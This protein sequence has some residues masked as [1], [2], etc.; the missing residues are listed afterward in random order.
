[1]ADAP[2]GKMCLEGWKVQTVQDAVTRY[3]ALSR[4]LDTPMGQVDLIG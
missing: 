2:C 1:M 4:D 3:A